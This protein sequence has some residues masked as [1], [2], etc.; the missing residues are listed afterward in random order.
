M[1]NQRLLQHAAGLNEQTAIDRLVRHPERLIL[2]VVPSQPTRDLLRRPVKQQQPPHLAT[3]QRV[4]R[5]LTRL[6]TPRSVPSTLLGSHRAVAAGTAVA[7]ELPTDCGG[8]SPQLGRDPADRRAV[9]QVAGNLFAFVKAQRQ[10]RTTTHLRP[11]PTVG[12]QVRKDHRGGLPEY[13]TDRFEPFAS[14]PPI[15]DLRAL[16]RCEEPALRTL[17]HDTS[18][19]SSR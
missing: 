3:Q 11:N 14:L 10:P 6:G 17:M 13:P 19:L 7:T 16:S 9:H 15:P 5:Q 18:P 12:P 1:L 4:A 2:R 8:G